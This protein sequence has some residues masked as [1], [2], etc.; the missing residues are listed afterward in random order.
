MPSA[1]RQPVPIHEHALDSLRYI[2][3]TM[4][5]AS[6][7]TAV[8]GWG[9]AVMG[10]T[11]IVAA[12]LA[13]VQKDQQGW[14]SVW[15]TEALVAVAIGLYAMHRKAVAAGSNLT[16]APYRKFVMS[17]IPPL[18]A[19]A[20]LTFALYPAGHA[21]MLPGIWLLLY[22]TGVMTG[23]AFS[24]RIVPAL[25]ACFI[26]LGAVCLFAPQS[27][28]NWFLLAGFGVLHLVFGFVIA[29]RYGG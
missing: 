20:A 23:G 29:K 8:P 26:G 25:G 1:S 27:W 24:I 10:A 9:G 11:A 22:G 14:L 3:E 28:G 16:A 7:F 21:S 18:F 2:R 15:M 13:A 5:R 19:G 12:F 6:S 4:E 17:F